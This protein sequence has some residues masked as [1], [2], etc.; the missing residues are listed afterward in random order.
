MKKETVFLVAYAYSL[1]NTP[2]T[3]DSIKIT[4]PEERYFLDP[5]EEPFKEMINEAICKKLK[6]AGSYVVI[7]VCRIK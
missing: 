2:Q 3:L 6:C 7:N 5:S 1:F 4:V